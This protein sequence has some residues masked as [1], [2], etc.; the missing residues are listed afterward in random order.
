MKIINLF[1]VLTK[2]TAKLDK[3]VEAELEIPDPPSEQAQAVLKVND[4]PSRN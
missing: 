4:D 3:E 1:D 2:A